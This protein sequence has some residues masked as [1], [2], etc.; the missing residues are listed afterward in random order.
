V[1]GV[2]YL[3]YVL[4]AVA[5]DNKPDVAVDIAEFIWLVVL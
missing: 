4:A 2:S 3:W 5:E 1:N